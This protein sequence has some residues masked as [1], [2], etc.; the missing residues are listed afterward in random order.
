M[1]SNSLNHSAQEGLGMV[2]RQLN[3]CVIKLFQ[4]NMMRHLF[5]M[6]WTVIRMSYSD[7]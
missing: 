4:E 1:D 5:I 2:E 6:L 7:R 3:D